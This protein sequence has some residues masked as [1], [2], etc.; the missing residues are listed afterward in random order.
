MVLCLTPVRSATRLQQMLYTD[1]RHG[2]SV[3]DVKRLVRLANL[4]ATSETWLMG[5]CSTAEQPAQLFPAYPELSRGCPGS[6]DRYRDAIV[7]YLMDGQ[8]YGEALHD[9]EALR[10]DALHAAGSSQS[11]A[12]AREL[13]VSK[14]LFSS[15]WGNLFEVDQ[16]PLAVTHSACHLYQLKYETELPLVYLSFLCQLVN[17]GHASARMGGFLDKKG[18]LVKGRVVQDVLDKLDRV[19]KYPAFRA[20]FTDAYSVE[21]RR[22][23]AHNKY[24]IR[25]GVIASIDGTFRASLVDLRR[26]MHSITFVQN[27]VVWQ[28]RRS[29]QRDAMPASGDGVLAVG[30]AP[31]PERGGPALYIFALAPLVESAALVVRSFRTV[32]FSREGELL[33]TSLSECQKQRGKLDDTRAWLRWAEGVKRLRAECI[34]VMPCIHSDCHR[35]ALAGA[36]FCQTAGGIALELESVLDADL[37]DSL[38]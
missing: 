18:H 36:D 6:L 30:F 32:S 5:G 27:A 11:D 21:L 7:A 29:D 38:R 9:L 12:I 31:H 1:A 34:P 25:D 13:Y 15:Q 14:E 37:A 4:F 10:C 20:A 23:I 3:V 8:G 35:L 24:V 33:L 17:S 19:K 28:L 2:G 22:H 26:A 16:G